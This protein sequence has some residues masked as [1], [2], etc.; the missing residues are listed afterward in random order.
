MLLNYGAE[1]DRCTSHG[2]TAVMFAAQNGHSQ[3]VQVQHAML[4][5]LICT[6]HGQCHP[7]DAYCFLLAGLNYSL[8]VQLY[9]LLIPARIHTD[10]HVICNSLKML[11]DR[12]ARTE[13]VD[14]FYNWTALMY[15][16]KNGHLQVVEVRIFADLISN[17]TDTMY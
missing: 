12:G 4:S 14:R 6:R 16:A 10:N 15:A 2:L 17:A 13:P 8:Y 9:Q 11:L 5:H 7:V 1:V 3:I